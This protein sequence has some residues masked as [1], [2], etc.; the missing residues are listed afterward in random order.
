[1]R[2]EEFLSENTQRK[3]FAKG[4]AFFAQGDQAGAAYYIIQGEVE[5]FQ[6]LSGAESIMASLGPDEIFG[7]MA[8]LR[9]DEYTLSAKAAVDTE[10]YII[11]PEVLQ[12][13]I[14]DTH[15]L[16]KAILDM[17]LDRIQNVNEVLTD[18]DITNTS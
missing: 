15:P 14:R 8:L 11:T 12:V 3:S 6:T 10:V 17:L 5:I 13:Q 9:F 4:E 2:L 16:V 1:M 7:E 18:L